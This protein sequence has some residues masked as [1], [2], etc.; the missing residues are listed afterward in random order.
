MRPRADVARL[1]EVREER[2]LW[3]D[4]LLF[5]LDARSRRAPSPREQG[6]LPPVSAG[7]NA[8]TP[9]GAREAADPA[10]EQAIAPYRALFRPTTEVDPETG[11][12]QGADRA[13][14]IRAAFANAVQ[15]AASSRGGA[16]PTAAEIAAA[17]ERDPNLA[18]ARAYRTDLGELVAAAN[19]ALDVDQRARFREL[20]LARVAPQDLS[21]AEFD[22][23]IP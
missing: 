21:A 20:L 3:A 18:E 17:I 2:P 6:A 23:L 16:T 10:V 12:V 5:Y 22:A 14:E 4:E 8:T 9:D 19:R 1:A 15:V 11:I 7:P 13:P